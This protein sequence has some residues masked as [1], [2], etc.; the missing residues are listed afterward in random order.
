MKTHLNILMTENESNSWPIIC[1]FFVIYVIVFFMCKL[2]LCVYKKSWTQIFPPFHH[3]NGFVTINAL[4]HSMYTQ[5]AVI[6]TKRA[7][8][9]HDFLHRAHFISTNLS[10]LYFKNHS[11]QHMQ[12]FST[13]TTLHK[14]MIPPFCYSILSEKISK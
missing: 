11:R 5:F 1:S 13:C 7:H 3:H 9:F 4:G 10:V 14:Y 6:I 8:C 2:F 12:H